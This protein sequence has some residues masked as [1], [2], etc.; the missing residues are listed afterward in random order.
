M[1]E[2]GQYGP[3]GLRW[4]WDSETYQEVSEEDTRDCTCKGCEAFKEGYIFW[5][6]ASDCAFLWVVEPDQHER[7]YLRSKVVGPIELDIPYV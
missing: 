1:H 2:H 7:T 5:N 6:G 4:I 3:N